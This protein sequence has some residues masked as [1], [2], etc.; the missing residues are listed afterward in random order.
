MLCLGAYQ[1]AL[2]SEIGFWAAIC[3]MVRPVT[4][5]VVKDGRWSNPGERLAPGEG[6]IFF[7]PTS[8]YKSFSFVGQV[9]TGNLS[10]PVPSGFSIRS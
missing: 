8:D 4:E 7:N 10:L 2:A 6:A 9:L 3:F 5:N 1:S